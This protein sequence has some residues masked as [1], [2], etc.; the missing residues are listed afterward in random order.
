MCFLIKVALDFKEYSYSVCPNKKDA[1]V[2][3]VRI[4][5]FQNGSEGQIVVPMGCTTILFIFCVYGL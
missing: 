5:I 2:C 4:K 3:P 1:N